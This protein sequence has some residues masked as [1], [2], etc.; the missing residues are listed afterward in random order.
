MT[1][2]HRR[3]RSWLR[4][5]SDCQ[6]PFDHGIHLIGDFELDDVTGPDRLA[7]ARTVS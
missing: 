4:H 2:G 3:R 6:E 7:G 1:L 5:V